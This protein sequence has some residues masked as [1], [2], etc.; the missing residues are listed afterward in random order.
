ML[1]QTYESSGR[2][3]EETAKQCSLRDIAS[4]AADE[5]PCQKNCLLI[6]EW[7]ISLTQAFDQRKRRHVAFLVAHQHAILPRH[8]NVRSFAR[9]PH[10]AAPKCDEPLSD[11][12]QIGEC[13]DQL[14]STQAK[15]SV[16]ALVHH[17]SPSE[18]MVTSV[19]TPG[20]SRKELLFASHCRLS[21]SQ[22]ANG[23]QTAHSVDSAFLVQVR[24]LSLAS[25]RDLCPRGQ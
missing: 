20:S 2:T 3:T 25:A 1:Q 12:Q 4:F 19:A 13:T 9:C 24:D 21:T 5:S 23:R 16:R 8:G 11:Q 15:I 18:P 10:P 7:S 22:R 6:P 14:V 17:S